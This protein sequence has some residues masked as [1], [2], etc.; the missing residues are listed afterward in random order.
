MTKYAFKKNQF[1]CCAQSVV[2]NS[3]DPVDSQGSSVYGIFQARTL[4]WV[5]IFSSRGPSWPRAWTF[6]SYIS[7]IGRRIFFF[8]KPLSHLGNQYQFKDFILSWPKSY[9]GFF[10]LTDKPERTFWPTQYKRERNKRI[11]RLNIQV[12]IF[13]INY[14]ICL[15][16]LT[17]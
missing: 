8:F 2:S 11:F 9:F 6:V 15:N 14:L 10:L 4:Q 13:L 7:C 12:A 16:S 5:A 3:F 17:G 1:V